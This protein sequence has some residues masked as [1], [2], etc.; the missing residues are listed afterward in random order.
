[1]AAAAAPRWAVMDVAAA[2]A[3]AESVLTVALNP[4]VRVEALRLLSKCRAATGDRSAACEAS[5]SAAAAAAGAGYVWMEYRALHD[6]Q[7]LCDP[8]EADAVRGRVDE[9]A[10]RMAAS[11]AELKLALQGMV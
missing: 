7:R 2:A 8:A 3:V 4:L 5:E 9:V 11:P 10:S 1:M 6:L